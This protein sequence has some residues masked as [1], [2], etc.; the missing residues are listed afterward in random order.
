MR[1]P[2]KQVYFADEDYEEF[3]QEARLATLRAALDEGEA[4]PDVE[5]FDPE[6]FLQELKGLK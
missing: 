6:R 5:D 2:E 4:S 1:L 3:I